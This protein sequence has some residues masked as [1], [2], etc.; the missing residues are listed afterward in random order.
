MG[1]YKKNEVIYLGD[2]EYDYLCAKNARI[3]YIHANWGY[4]KIQIKKVK[5]INK[6]TDLKGYLNSEK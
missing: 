2:T 6:L 1:T 3:K 5:K 4:Q